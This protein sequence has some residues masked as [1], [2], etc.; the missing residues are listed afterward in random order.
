MCFSSEHMAQSCDSHGCKCCRDIKDCKNLKTELS[1]AR[2]QGI[3][4]AFQECIIQF[5]RKK[6]ISKGRS[7]FLASCPCLYNRKGR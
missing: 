6:A 7:L 4:I 3:A 1:I 2:V 5:A